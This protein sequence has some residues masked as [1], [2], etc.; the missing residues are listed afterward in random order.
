MN[1]GDTKRLESQYRPRHARRLAAGGYVSTTAAY[2]A[3]PTGPSVHDDRLTLRR[4]L[5][6]QNVMQQTLPGRGRLCI[7]IALAVTVETIRM[8]GQRFEYADNEVRK[9]RRR[10]THELRHQPDAARMN[11]F[12]RDAVRIGAVV[13]DMFENTFTW[14]TKS[15]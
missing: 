12:D 11:R 1:P 13:D 9:L 5:F 14:H 2:R 4:R 6:V 7:D 10:M 3:P 8:Y 15:P